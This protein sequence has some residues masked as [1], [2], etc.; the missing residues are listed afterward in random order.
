MLNNLPFLFS[1]DKINKIIEIKLISMHSQNVKSDLINQ[2]S[3]ALCSSLPCLIKKLLISIQNCT[4][5]LSKNE[6]FLM[7]FSY[8][9]FWCVLCY[10]FDYSTVGK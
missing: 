9:F 3:I 7:S 1:L 4:I 10:P 8:F 6:T 5:F 2:L